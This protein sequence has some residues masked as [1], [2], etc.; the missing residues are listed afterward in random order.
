MTQH[1]YLRAM[2]R[3]SEL[4]R[5]LTKIPDVLIDADDLAIRDDALHSIGVLASLESVE[6]VV[7]FVGPSGAGRSWVF[8]TFVGS[9]ISAEGAIRPTTTECIAATTTG[10]PIDG[11]AGVVYQVIDLADSLVVIDTPSWEHDPSTVAA[12][13]RHAD[14]VVVVVSPSR[15]ADA[16]VAALWTKVGRSAVLVLNRV[17]A[18]PDETVE[19][20]RSVESVFG[21][22]PIVVATGDTTVPALRSIITDSL[23]TDRYA[24][25]RTIVTNAL[26]SSSR[27]LARATASAA[28]E[29]AAVN[30]AVQSEG[31]FDVP[32]AVFNV[33]DSWLATKQS[34]VE[35][36]ATEIRGGDD[37]IVRSANVPLAERLRVD[38]GP[39]T[40]DVIDTDLDLWRDRCRGMFLERASIRWRRGSAEQLIDHYSWK[41]AINRNVIAPR[42]LARIMGKHLEDVTS[43]AHDELLV[44][45]AG[46]VEERRRTWMDSLA[47]LGSYQPGRLLA[48]AD[49][50]R[51]EVDLG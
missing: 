28:G 37:R 9:V 45:L 27:Y 5:A 31:E 26:R 48:F 13:V 29:I 51:F 23:V 2:E 25:E 43:T 17:E 16:S 14:L 35:E 32:G 22:E 8:N 47:R 40:E 19:L 4:R 36:V 49:E 34:M 3:V 10:L 24:S 33:A 18:T 46:S 39:W 20:E 42:R 41:T 7:V 1:R 15:Y 38:N 21:V 11:F 12:L 50:P 44:I 30:T 6:S